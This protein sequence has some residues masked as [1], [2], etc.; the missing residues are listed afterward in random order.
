MSEQPDISY[1]VVQK[2]SASPE[3]IYRV[4]SDPNA[5]LEWAG[6]KAPMIFKLR[7]LQAP[8]G[9]LSVGQSWTSHGVVGYFKMDD[10]STVVSADPG[11]AFGFDTD[12][13]VPRKIRPTWLGHF[14]N[15]YTIQPDGTGS[16]V[17]YTCDGYTVN[18][19]SFMWWP[20]FRPMTKAMYTMMIKR[21]LKKL[22]RQA[23][24]KSAVRA[25]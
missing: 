16:L 20:A 7:D 25:A 10:K 23:A 15:R 2:M 11:K 3:A 6:K 24:A 8:A 5:S 21:T 18:Y 19:R 12:S 22:E 1:R 14:E 9:P 13:T 4:L 17:E